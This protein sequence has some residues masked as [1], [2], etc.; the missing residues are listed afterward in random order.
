MESTRLHFY[1]YDERNKYRGYNQA[2]I[3]IQISIPIYLMWGHGKKRVFPYT[4]MVKVGNLQKGSVFW[5][6]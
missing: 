4:H 6:G 2:R 1:F 5:H 3:M